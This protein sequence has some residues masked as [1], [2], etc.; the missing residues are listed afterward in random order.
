MQ[1]LILMLFFLIVFFSR[2]VLAQTCSTPPDCNALGYTKT[3]EE[4]SG[5][6]MVLC[7][8]NQKQAFCAKNG[9][10]VSS[11]V[12]PGMIVYADGTVSNEIFDGKTPAGVVAFAKR[13]LRFMAALEETR[14]AWGPSG[15]VPCLPNLDTSDGYRDLFGLINT[16]C[17]MEQAE[18][19]PAAQYCHDYQPVAEGNYSNGWF[20]PATGEWKY[21]Q[22]T[23]WEVNNTLQKLGKTPFQDQLYFSST[24]SNA[25]EGAVQEIMPLQ[26]STMT[27]SP[28][29]KLATINVRCFHTF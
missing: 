16:R 10:N 12:L 9:S 22:Y 13:G 26:N 3:A 27:T 21:L 24:E 5:E 1:K 7:P 8:S 20:L 6:D 19:Y 17:I 11:E 4:C 15:D 29:N 2:N 25:Y 18:D 14:K 23:V 28:D